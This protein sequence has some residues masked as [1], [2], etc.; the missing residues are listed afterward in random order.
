MDYTPMDTRPLFASRRKKSRVAPW[1]RV[2]AL[3]L[4][5]GSL[6]IVIAKISIPTDPA[7]DKSVDQ[8]I[9]EAITPVEIPL[10]EPGDAPQSSASL[11]KDDPLSPQNLSLTGPEALPATP[12]PVDT[13]IQVKSGDN[14]STIFSRLG[15]SY[16][17]VSDVIAVGD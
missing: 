2:S 10:T 7:Q 9:A 5:V 1:L 17:T 13:T 14:L 12:E 3:I 15:L 16:Q 8:S 4:G 6:G 11:L